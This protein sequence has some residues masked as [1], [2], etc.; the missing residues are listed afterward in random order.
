MLSSTHRTNLKA[1][2]L[3]ALAVTCAATVALSAC[4]GQ[5]V[6]TSSTAPASNTPSSQAPTSDATTTS[7]PATASSE[8]TTSDAAKTSD[9]P[10]SAAPVKKP[11]DYVVKD[12]VLGNTIA[13]TSVVRNFP[14]PDK[15]ESLKKDGELVLVEVDAKAGSKFSGGVQGG[16]KLLTADGSVGNATTIADKE[17]TAAGYMPFDAP[18]RGGSAK[19]WVA[20]Q[21]NQKADSFRLSYKRS[22]ATVIGSDQVI[23]AKTWEFALK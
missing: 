6:S 9:A 8:A 11:L 1:A 3:T 15:F 20:F 17:M 21:V 7:S 19:G 18:S 10:G 5:Q 13:F 16:W 2:R 23:P 4:S 12:D 14:V 22:A